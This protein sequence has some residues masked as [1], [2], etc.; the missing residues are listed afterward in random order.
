MWTDPGERG[1]C[2]RV[3]WRTVYCAVNMAYCLLRCEPL[4]ELHLVVFCRAQ[5][6]AHTAGGGIDSRGYLLAAR[7]PAIRIAGGT[8]FVFQSDVSTAL[9]CIAAITY[10]TMT[11]SHYYCAVLHALRHCGVAT[12]VPREYCWYTVEA[13]GT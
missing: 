12:V 1:L 7:P 11:P 3:D 2:R 13:C 5:S 10:N 9:H 4:F 8:A 6:A